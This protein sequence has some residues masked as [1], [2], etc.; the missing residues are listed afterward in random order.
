M[1]KHYHFYLLNSQSRDERGSSINGG[2]SVLLKFSDLREVE[3]YI[4]IFYLEYSSF[5]CSLF[6]NLAQ[7]NYASK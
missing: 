5:S 3:K 2:T 6:M 1:R 7:I 4:Q